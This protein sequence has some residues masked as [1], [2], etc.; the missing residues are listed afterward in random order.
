MAV[1]LATAVGEGQAREGLL[2]EIASRVVTP[3]PRPQLTAPEAAA[4]RW[5]DLLKAG[6][7]DA[8]QA[9]TCARAREFMALTR[10]A[11]GLAGTRGMQAALQAGATIDFSGLRYETLGQNAAFSFVRIGGNVVLPDGR[12][13]PFY[14]HNTLGTNVAEIR[15]EDGQWRHCDYVRPSAR[16]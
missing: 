8:L 13:V 6:N 3:S 7:L 15:F 9:H 2:Y 14:A 10:L 4:K 16:R 12:A 1:N 11:E 5:F